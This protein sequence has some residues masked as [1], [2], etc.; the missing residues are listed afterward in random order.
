MM[1]YR[2]RWAWPLLLAM[3]PAIA[4]AMPADNGVILSARQLQAQGI[5]LAPLEPAT[6]TPAI[7]GIASVRDPAPLLATAA[8]LASARAQAHAAA[9]TAAAARAQSTRLAALGPQGYVAQ[10]EVQTTAAQATAAE[11]QHAAA[12]AQLGALQA[13]ARAQWGEVLALLAARGTPA[14]ADYAQGRATLVELALPPGTEAPPAA[15]ITLQPTGGEPLRASLLGPAPQA[16]LVVQGPT[17]FYRVDGGSLRAG[18]RL[19]ARMPLPQ[20]ARAGVRVPADAVIW[21]AGQ[22]WVFA[23]TA[24]GRFQRQPL[25]ATARDA[26]GWFV[27]EGL[28]R[29]QRVVVRG[30]ELL[31]S[32]ELKPPPGARPAMGDDD[33]DD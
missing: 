4:A 26:Q 16:D 29:G 2:K 30:A 3:L 28:R 18:Q 8:N 17:Y 32:Q 22:P 7:E 33:D 20:P 15:R 23:E 13:A 24:P 27:S 1:E 14:L 21:Y 6:Q 11:A 19:D 5:R 10:N 9:A 12:V 31:L 25:P